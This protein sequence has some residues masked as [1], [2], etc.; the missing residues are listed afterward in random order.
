MRESAVR[1]RKVVALDS[2][3]TVGVVD[4]FVV[5]PHDARVAALRLRK[6]R[7]QATVLPW[8]AIH[9]FGDDAITVTDADRI[10]QPGPDLAALMGKAGAVLGKRVLSSAG[11]ELGAVRDV[12]IDTATGSVVS[13]IL[14]DRTVAGD[15]MLGAGS[16][17][18]MVRA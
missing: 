2:A 12:D 6:T 16:F 4:G 18:V 17:A 14:G 3:S 8:T 10:V 15:R 13:L 1:G 5:D 9:G 7:T 11:A